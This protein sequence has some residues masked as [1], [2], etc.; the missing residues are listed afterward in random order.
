MLSSRPT[1]MAFAVLIAVVDYV[2][3]VPTGWIAPASAQQATERYVP[4]GKSPGLSGVATVMGTVE[5]L[6]LPQ[7]R[8]T[9]RAASGLRQLE[10]TDETRIWLDRSSLGETNLPAELSECR[11][12]R[13]LEVRLAAG[14]EV[15]EWIK[16]RAP[17]GP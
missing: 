17:E 12:G 15:A 4:I 11:E 16:I 8:L 2:A 10:V 3:A 9:L 13:T 1:C 5:A 6:D 7:R 14:G